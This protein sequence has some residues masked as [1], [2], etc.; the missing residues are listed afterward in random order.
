MD[1]MVP[2]QARRNEMRAM[3]LA[4]STKYQ[5]INIS[6]SVNNKIILYFHSLCV[7]I[8]EYFELYSIRCIYSAHIG[9]IAWCRNVP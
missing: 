7:Y 1:E 4:R 3:A 8:L 5:Y 6:I 9:N 2:F